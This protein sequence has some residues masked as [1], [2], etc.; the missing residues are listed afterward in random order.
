[1]NG[2]PVFA[3]DARFSNDN[4]RQEGLIGEHQALVWLPVKTGENEI[5]LALTEN[6]GG[7]GLIGR[8]EP[9][10]GLDS[11]S[12]PRGDQNNISSTC[13]APW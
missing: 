7:R 6:F 1:M 13:H 9:A 3:G 10:D 2:R 4:P 12:R 5:L 8:L 11:F